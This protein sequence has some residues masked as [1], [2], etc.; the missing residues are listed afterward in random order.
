MG[1]KQIVYLSE[2]DKNTL[3]NTGTLTKDGKTVTY[4][5]DNIYMTPTPETFGICSTGANTAA[6]TATITDFALIEGVTVSIQFTHTNTASNPTLNISSTGAVPIYK[7]GTSS[8]GITTATSWSDGAIVSLTYNGTGW[9]V[10]NYTMSAEGVGGGSVTSVRVQATSPIVSSTSTAQTT[11]LDTTISLANANANTVLAGPSNGSSAAAPSYRSLVSADIPSHNHAV[12]DI[13]SGTLPI[14]RGGTNATSFTSNKVLTYNGTSIVSKSYHDIA[15]TY[16]RIYSDNSTNVASVYFTAKNS[17]R[18]VSL[19]AHPDGS[20]G[21]YDDTNSAWLIYRSTTNTTTTIPG[22]V[23]L[24]TV[25][26]GTWNGTAITATYIGSHNHAAG[27]INSGTLGITRGGTGTSTAPTQYG[28]IYASSTSAYASTGA[29]SS[30][31][32]LKSNGTSAPTWATFNASTVGLGNV[33]NTKLSTWTGSAN[34]KTVGTITSGTWNGTAIASSY[35]GSHTH[36]AS[37]I[38]SGQLA[39]TYGGTGASTAE[40]AKVNLGICAAGQNAAVSNYH[41]ATQHWGIGVNVLASSTSGVSKAFEGKRTSLIVVDNG[42]FVWN[43]TDSKSVWE[44]ALGTNGISS[45]VYQTPTE[46]SPGTVK[47]TYNLRLNSGR[48]YGIVYRSDS[49]DGVTYT[50]N[51]AG[52]LYFPDNGYILR[53]EAPSGVTV[54]FQAAGPTKAISLMVNST[55]TNRGLYDAT[56]DNWLIR[57]DDSSN[58]YINSGGTNSSITLNAKGTGAVVLNNNTVVNGDIHSGYSTD[59]TTR[60]AGTRSVGGRL[61][62]YTEGTATST[63][64]LW[65]YNNAGTGRDIITIPQTGS[66]KFFGGIMDQYDNSKTITARYYG[67]GQAATDWVCMWT[68]GSGGNGDMIGAVSIVDA[69]DKA[70]IYSSSTP[71]VVNG[72]LWLKPV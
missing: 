1:F 9:I 65:F 6:K 42:L 52:N 49:N 26:A 36:A 5:E 37:D 46:D 40:N 27:D 57:L 58:A 28:I 51:V 62:L 54:A 15:D 59:T 3:F 41:G 38:T 67:S 43:N 33:E 53:N 71:T 21:V 44:Y 39:V 25:T 29:G 31:Q 45:S 19:W 13:T 17:M 10:N 64:G 8:V 69:V 72:K 4:D 56:I 24:G 7:Y 14:A 35:I 23:S 55:D 12:G 34:I 11:A 60:R 20:I 30:G 47:K 63:S 2:T 32:Y 18:S 61:F 48:A 16:Y 50:W 66:A 70:I 22:N 68:N